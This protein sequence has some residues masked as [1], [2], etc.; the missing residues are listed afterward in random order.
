M[1]TITDAIDKRFGKSLV[2]FKKLVD[3]KR[4]KPPKTMRK[5]EHSQRGF[6]RGYSVVLSW[7]KIEHL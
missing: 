5:I 6:Y 2:A 3:P 7:L 1:E 4:A